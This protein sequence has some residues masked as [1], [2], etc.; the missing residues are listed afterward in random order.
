MRTALIGVGVMG[1]K[2]AEMICD[3]NVKNTEL[4]AV[5]CRNDK[6]KQ[7]AA[8]LKGKPVVFPDADSLFENS[9]L[10]DCV[11]IATPHKTHRE[12]A[13][14]AFA[15]GKHVMCD[16]PAGVSVTDAAAMTK[17]AESSGKV[18]GLMFHQRMYPKYKEIK[19]ILDSG[20][21]GKLRRIMMVNSRYLRTSHY[22]NSGSWRSSWTG[23]GGGALINQGQHILDIWQWLFGMPEKIYADIPFGKYNDF[24]VDDEATIH[25]RYSDKL[26]AVF[27]LSTGEAVWQERLEITGTKGKILLEDDLLKISY[28]DDIEEY[29]AASQATSREELNMTQEEIQFEKAE[30][31]YI[32]MLENFE[33]AVNNGKELTAP[34]SSGINAIML[35]NAAYYSAWTGKPVELPLDG[36]AY[37]TELKKHCN[38]EN[39]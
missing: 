27:M 12:L 25:M 31:P 14:K 13:E 4:T 20:K 21:L 39:K 18:Y 10:Y 24:L 7:W 6:A 9:G 26:T 33:Q 34:G 37:D 35:T 2:Y 8:S 5:V 29:I 16:K 3:G 1:K 28:F 17:A 32:P 19:N 30:E 22:H 23:E 38:M 15:L 36:N 11:I